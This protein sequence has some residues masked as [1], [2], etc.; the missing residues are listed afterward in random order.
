MNN[1]FIKSSL[2]LFK[3]SRS[4]FKPFSLLLGSISGLWFGLEVN[5]NYQVDESVIEHLKDDSQLLA[6][7]RDK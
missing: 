2:G 7:L 6:S 5:K 3:R 4:L 1:L